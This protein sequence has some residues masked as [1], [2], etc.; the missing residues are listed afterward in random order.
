MIFKNN[1]YLFIKNTIP[2]N[3]ENFFINYL[4][5]K[6]K[7]Y[8]TYLD[9]KYISP[10]NVD[11]GTYEDA[12]IPNT[13]SC[14]G[15]IAMDTLLSMV[16]PA[17]EKQTKLKLYETY[18]YTRLYKKGDELVKHIDRPSCE[19]STTLNLGGDHWPIFL[20]NSKGKEVKVDLNIS[21]MLIYRGCDLEHWRE[22]FDGQ[23]CGQVFLHYNEIKN[24]QNENLYDNRPHLG[25]PVFFKDP[26]L[27]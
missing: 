12:Q 20:K 10:Y 6:R 19:I 13:W 17:M 9:W 8:N 26:N 2:L 24:K 1:I 7:V 18:A 14:Y 16:K 4:K 22:P 11:Y 27:K 5:L 25:L 23:I 15:D 21:D 3:F